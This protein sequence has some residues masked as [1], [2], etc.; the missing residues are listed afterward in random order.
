M[1]SIHKVCGSKQRTAPLESTW[2]PCSTVQPK[3]REGNWVVS[4]GSWRNTWWSDSL[5]FMSSKLPV[6]LLLRCETYLTLSYHLLYIGEVR[7]LQWCYLHP[8]WRFC[9]FCPAI[10]LNVLLLLELCDALDTISAPVASKF[11]PEWHS[12]WPEWPSGQV[13]ATGANSGGHQNDT[14]ITGVKISHRS[15]SSVT[16]LPFSCQFHVLMLKIWMQH[17]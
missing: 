13:L 10:Q 15:N 7:T 8:Y 16:N 4:M 1:F 2:K 17:H 9:V 14:G 3:P 12:G 6:G 11:L 5:T